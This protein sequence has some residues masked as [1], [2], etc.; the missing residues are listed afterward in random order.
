MVAAEVA[1]VAEAKFA[2]AIDDKFKLMVDLEL[3]FVISSRIP[4]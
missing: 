3:D 2:V 1:V 4:R